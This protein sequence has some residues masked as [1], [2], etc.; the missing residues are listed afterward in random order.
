[1][2]Y[3]AKAKINLTLDVVG[4]LPDGYHQIKSL[5][6]K[7]PLFD[8]IE[9][10]EGEKGIYFTG[11]GVREDNTVKKALDLF[12]KEINVKKE[13]SVKIIKNIP[14]GS[15]LGGGSSDAASV[16]K[17]LNSIFGYP[18]SLEDLLNIG[19]EIGSDVPLF[20]REE[21][22]LLIENKGEKVMPIY[23]KDREF[24]IAVVF[25][26]FRISTSRVYSLVDEYSYFNTSTDTVLDRL[27]SN[28]DFLSYLKNDLEKFAI[29]LNPGLVKFKEELK[30]FNPDAL[31]LS[32]SG[33]SYALFFKNPQSLF[34][35]EKSLK[36]SPLQV[37]LFHVLGWEKIYRIDRQTKE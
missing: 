34:L 19:A 21:N 32:G 29:K 36:N 11:E 16:L 37:F 2:R 15:G 35:L 7:I 1:M 17:A 18:L 33:S 4:K 22:L 9:I 10:D 26:G 31:V 30:G 3:L 24:F 6:L 23:V 28:E 13:F 8:V 5:V 25:P 27:I 12:L 20:I 14:I